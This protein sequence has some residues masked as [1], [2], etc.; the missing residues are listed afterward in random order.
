MLP[1]RG[2]LQLIENVRDE[3]DAMYPRQVSQVRCG[4]YTSKKET[5]GPSSPGAVCGSEISA[6]LVESGADL[7]AA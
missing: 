6:A 4:D 7:G 2:T 1:R 5:P 3:H